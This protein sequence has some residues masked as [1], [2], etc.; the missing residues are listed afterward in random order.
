MNAH[1]DLTSGVARIEMVPGDAFAGCDMTISARIDCDP[2]C[3]IAGRILEIRDATGNLVAEMAMAA[4]VDDG[5]AFVA[6]TVVKAPRRAGTSTWHARLA[7]HESDGVAYPE[8]TL[9]FDV[10]TKAH[11]VYLNVWD[12]PAC[13]T[14]GE[15]ITFKVGVKCGA[16]CACSGHTVAV[17]DEDGNRIAM[18][19]TGD[20]PQEGT[21]AV[22][23]ALF[24]ADAP[25]RNGAFRW[26]ASLLDRE[27]DLPHAPASVPCPIRVVPEPEVTLTVEAIAEDTGEAVRGARVVMH[28][29][30]AQTDASGIARIEAARG[31]Y[32]VVV[33]MS[34]YDPMSKQIQ[35]EGDIHER[36]TLVR[37]A[38]EFNP[39]DNY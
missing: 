11:P 35:L 15:R 6:D 21:E 20:R 16:G 7:V 26:H 13:A 31:V 24:E 19:E 32:S 14:P 38:P 25:E 36:V 33:S 10:E 30:R 37:E 2:P 1:Q 12:L 4:P 27:G 5:T 18:A 28:P 22:Y 29:Y 34:K 17:F 3:D 23:A 9:A 39:D 8:A